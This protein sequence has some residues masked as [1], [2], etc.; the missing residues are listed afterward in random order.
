MSE[1]V[2]PR[3]RYNATRRQHQ[4]QETRRRI[5]EAAKRLFVEQG[6]V[7]TS[8]ETIAQAAGVAAPTVYAAFGNKRTLLTRL[9]D[10]AIA[11]DDQP[12]PILQRP[13]PQQMRQAPDQHQQLRL[14]AHGI[15]EVLQRAGPLFDVMRSAA[16]VDPEIALLYQRLQE[17]RL[18]NMREIVE[19][20]AV[21]G[22]LR[23]AL[24]VGDAADILWTFTSADVQRL[25][26]IDRGWSPEQYAQWLA[27]ALTRLLLP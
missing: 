4:A 3:R 2:K 10:L 12:L 18:R 22:P 15:G 11:G 5:L 8:I 14:I 24:S 23:S 26:T 19:W 17:E 9:M 1:T 16:L 20:V 21:N 13:G 25:L 27:D 6:Y 7:T